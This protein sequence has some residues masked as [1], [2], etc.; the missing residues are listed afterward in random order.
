MCTLVLTASVQGSPGDATLKSLYEGHH[1]KQ[2]AAALKAGDG[3]ALYRG[4][5]AAAFN[6][7]QLAERLLNDAIALSPEGEAAYDAHEWLAHIYFRTGQ[8]RR[9][10]AQME[11]RWSKF[12]DR[13]ERKQEET[14]VAGFRDLPNL[15]IA[16]SGY[17]RLKIE[18]E[19]ISV[20][21]SINHRAASY[22]FDTGAWINCMSESEAKRLGLTVDRTDGSVTTGTGSSIGFRTAVA[23]ELTIGK[24][25]FRNV[26]FA[27]FPDNQEPWSD[28]PVSKRGLIGIPIL[29]GL[30][31]LRW[32]ADGV[33]EAGL[34]PRVLD[35]PS[36]NLFFDNDHLMIEASLGDRPVIATLD[37]GAQTTDLYAP[38]A[39]AFPDLLAR[40]GRRDKTEVRGVGDA[41]TFESFTLPDVGFRIGETRVA[42]RP[43]H[44]LLKQIGTQDRM[45]NF[46][47]DLLRQQ[48]GFRIDFRAMRLE[49]ADTP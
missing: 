35:V 30:R 26:S 40:E 44:V 7:D 36:S 18:P 27:I 46:G 49:L 13:A 28:L 6:Q 24:T 11:E 3:P 38:F 15:E 20:P 5:V 12:P 25:S 29:L 34:T 9:F 31:S 41:E 37:T 48:R 45:G 47:M 1:W 8:Y 14:T 16:A 23:P 19:K 32:Q 21:V 43:A 17:S 22:F 33:L 42:L 39:N 2:L 10:V 4:V